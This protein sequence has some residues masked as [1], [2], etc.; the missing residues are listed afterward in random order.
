VRARKTIG[1]AP[2]LA[3]LG[4]VLFLAPRAARGEA[5][6]PPPV[7]SPAGSQ[8]PPPPATPPPTA[9]PPPVEAPAAPRAER[10]GPIP[11]G[12]EAATATDHD[13]VVGRIG[14]EARRLDVGPLPLTLGSNGCPPA[15]TA[16]GQPCTVMMGVLGLR[17]WSTRNLAWNVGLAFA[18]GGGRSGTQALDSYVG[19]GPVVGLSVLLGNWRH[20]S[21]A[22]SP[23]LAFVWF[24]P[25]GDNPSTK[26]VQMRAALE[27]EL[28]FGFVHVPALSVGLLAG[29]GFQY[30]SVT[31]ARV[32]SVGVLGGQSVW[33][34]LT[35]LFVRYYL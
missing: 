17:Y 31:D 23:E 32:W 25:G 10:P 4:L 33:G 20:L 11:T 22:A 16:A 2:R 34:T 24:H 5:T 26:L 15:T 3:L 8:P 9:A 1:G 13:A 21:V 28:H 29:L 27:G 14:I 7:P 19:L 12:D 35:N 18:A 30:E 6:T